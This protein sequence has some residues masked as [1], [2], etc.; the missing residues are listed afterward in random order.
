LVVPW[1]IGQKMLQ[2]LIVTIW[3]GFRHPFE[4]GKNWG[5]YAANG[6]SSS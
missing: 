6:S 1:R 3:N 2:R 4:S 5:S